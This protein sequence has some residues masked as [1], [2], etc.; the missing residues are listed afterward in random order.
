[1]VIDGGDITE[2]SGSDV[3]EIDHSSVEKEISNVIE[4]EPTSINEPGMILVYWRYYIN[5]HSILYYTYDIDFC[6]YLRI[7]YLLNKVNYIVR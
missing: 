4:E 6:I 5:Y 2:L 3:A 7:S 1:M